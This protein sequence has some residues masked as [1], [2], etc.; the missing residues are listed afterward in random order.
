[1]NETPWI[2]ALPTHGP[3]VPVLSQ[4]LRLTFRVTSALTDGKQFLGETYCRL[5]GVGAGCSVVLIVL[6]K[7]KSEN[8]GKHCLIDKIEFQGGLWFVMKIY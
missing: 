1:M 4:P 5:L 7:L 6:P 3:P 8:V 2:P